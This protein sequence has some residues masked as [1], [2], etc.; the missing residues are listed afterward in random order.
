MRP[1]R[2]I[3]G[4][5]AAGLVLL[6]LVVVGAALIGERRGFPGPGPESVAWHIAVAVIAVV[7]QVYSDRVRGTASLVAAAVVLGS[8]AVLLWTQ[9]WG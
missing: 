7:A 8:G 5:A 9:W 3:S 1:I 4:I 2:G 6:A